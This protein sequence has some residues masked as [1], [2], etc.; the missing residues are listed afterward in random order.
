M[1]DWCV[2]RPDDFPL[3][4]VGPRVYRRTMSS[5][6]FTAMNDQSATDLA[7]RLNA[8]EMG[9][10]TISVWPNPDDPDNT[11]IR[12]TASAIETA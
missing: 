1:D 5:P 2:L 4:A 11:L 6:L 7:F 8:H 3:I 10:T 9:K 12:L